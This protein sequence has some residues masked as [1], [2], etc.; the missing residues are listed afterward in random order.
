M[1][2]RVLYAID[3]LF[4]VAV[5]APPLLVVIYRM[6][7]VPLRGAEIDEM[8]KA[9]FQNPDE[10]AR[11]A[12]RAAL[13]N[14][15][16]ISDPKKTFDHCHNPWRYALPLVVLFILTVSSAYVVYSWV[17]YRLVAPPPASGTLATSAAPL[18]PAS[19]TLATTPAQ[20]AVPSSPGAPAPKTSEAS[21]PI[22]EPIP[23]R[24][25]LV[26]IMAL[27]GGY[28][29]SVYQVFARIRASELS[30]GDLYEIDLGLLAAVPVG[31]AFSLITAELEGVRS[32]MAFAAS[33]FP[34]REV[35]R[36]VRQNATRKM[37]ESSDASTTRPTELHLGTAI[38]GLSDQTLA[39]LSE[40]RIT[41]VLD[42]AYCDPIKVMVQTGF[43]LPVIVDW[44][45][46]SL[47]ALYVGDLK[48]QFDKCGL[49]C[50]LDVC[51]FVD[52]H[53][54]DGE[55]KKKAAIS[56][57][58]KE[59]LDALAQKMCAPVLLQDLFFRIYVDPQVMVLRKL[60]YP[61]GVPKELRA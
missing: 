11:K 22:R 5:I 54:L 35:S 52:L 1:D 42:M 27:T 15:P 4:I 25:P 32:F 6:R 47:W 21:L 31:S 23:A 57:S 12:A 61:K 8:M 39:R 55:G 2:T 10:A 16:F 14:N 58:D 24:L 13:D 38:E 48:P 30:P 45:D 44:M 3:A 9:A 49:R 36:L 18:A 56:G 34:L 28:V 20:S 59:A 26:I 53:L 51:E 33:A 37:L 60:W 19:S 40:L 43:P 46:Q 7:D 41:T 29:W 17:Y 50:S